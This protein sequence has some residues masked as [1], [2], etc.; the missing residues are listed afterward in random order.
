MLTRIV[1]I[2]VLLPALIAC[3]D[4]KRS[5]SGPGEEEVV[6]LLREEALQALEDLGILYSQLSFID[7]AAVG[8]LTVVR[9]FV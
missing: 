6:V 2:T 9:L 8:D 1:F 7:H 4:I 5:P 3:S